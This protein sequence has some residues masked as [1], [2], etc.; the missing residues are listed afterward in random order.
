MLLAGW[1]GLIGY[2]LYATLGSENE[3]ALAMATNT[4]RANFFKDQAFRFWASSKG[5]LYAVV[6]DHTQPVP[7]MAHVPDRDLRAGDGR[8]LTLMNPA[9]MLREMMDQYADLYGIRGRIVGLVTL[10]PDNRA[11]PWEEKAIRAFG[12]GQKEVFE[13]SQVN[14]KP[15][16]RLIR[17]MVMQAPCMK[18]H[19]HLG[20]KIGDVRGAVGVSVPLE[21]YY[22]AAQTLHDRTIM[23]HGAVW[24]MGLVGGGIAFRAQRRRI[25]EREASLKD[26]ALAARVF[27]FGMQGIAITDSNGVI[28]RVNKAFTDITGYPAEEAVGRK[29]SLLKSGM[30]DEAF[31]ERMWRSI[32]S[33][34]H[35]KGEL[36]N[37]HKDGH[38]Y[39]VS[40]HNTAL[41]DD[42]GNVRHFIA[43]F[44]DITDRK[45]AES[46]LL[47]SEARYREAQ[48]TARLGHWSYD[49]ATERFLWWSEETFRLLGI[50]PA[51]GNPDYST[52]ISA[53][54]PED[55]G[56]IDQVVANCLEDKQPFVV[57]YRVP[58][59]G[60]TVR[61]LEAR[62]EVH[63]DQD[64]HVA[65]MSGTVM[66]VSERH[67]AV[68]RLETFRALADASVDAIVMANPD[69]TVVSYANRAAHTM[70]A[71]DFGRQEMVGRAG[72]VFWPPEDLDALEEVIH[73]AMAGGWHGDVRLRRVDGQPFDADIT[74]FAVGKAEGPRQHVVAIIR[75]ITD[76]KLAEQA[77][78]TANSKLEAIIDFLPDATLVTDAQGG[79]IA[80][81][82][83]MEA[84]TGVP[85][86]Q[87]IGQDSRVYKQAFYGHQRPMLVDLVLGRD[88]NGGSCYPHFEQQGDTTV[89]EGY[90][91]EVFGGQGAY[92]WATALPLRDEK[93]VMVGA[94]ECVRDITEAKSAEE[95]LRQKEERLRLALEGTTDGI[96]DWNL[97]SNQAYFSPRYYTML[98]YE[99]GE[100]P[101]GYEGWKQLLHPDDLPLAEAAIQSHLAQGREDSYA[102]EFRCRHKDGSWRWILGRG[103]VVERDEAGNPLRV[104]GS[105][106]DISAR[107]GSEDALLLTQFTVD[108]ASDA[109]FWNDISGRFT[110]VNDMA[111]QSL[112]Y[113]REE[114]LQLG[115][116]DVDVGVEPEAVSHVLAELQQVGAMQFESMHKRKDGSLF[117]VEVSLKYMAFSGEKHM[118]AHAR[119][120]TDRRRA[121]AALLREKQF[122][123][124]VINSL[125]GVFYVFDEH[126]RLV[127]WNQNLRELLGLP[128]ERLSGTVIAD[129]I[130]DQDR[131]L[132]MAKFQDVLVTGKGSAEARLQV[133]GGDRPSYFLTG[134]TLT[135]GGHTYVVGAGVDISAR[136]HAEEELKLMQF[137]VERSS[138]AFFLIDPKNRF[139][140]V[141]NTAC[142]SLGLTRK[143]LLAMSIE[144]IDPDIPGEVAAGMFQSLREHKALHFE[145]R[146]RRKDGSAFPVEVMANYIEFN[147]QE[148]NFCFAR[149][150]SQRKH[151]EEALAR[152][153]YAIEHSS[154]AFELISDTGQVIAC[155]IQAHESLGLTREELIGMHIWDYDP[156][157]A[158]ES[159]PHLWAAL[160]QAGSNVLE[161][162]HR[163]KDGSTFP[164]EAAINHVRFGDQE[165][166]FSYITDITARKAAENALRENEQYLRNLLEQ[167]PGTVFWKDRESVYRGCNLAFAQGAGFERVDDIVG[168]TDY[169][170]PWKESEATAYRRD[171]QEVMQGGRSKLDILETQL[172]ANGKQVRFNTSK[173]PIHDHRGEVVGV[174]GLSHDITQQQRA[175]EALRELNAT[176]ETRVRE[177]AQ[178]NREK[179][180]L[181]IQQSRLAAMGEMI[182]NIAHQWRQPINALGLVLANIRDAHEFGDLDQDYLHTQVDRGTNLIHKMSTTIDDFRN[183]FRPDRSRQVFSLA[184]AVKEALMVVELSFTHSNIRIELDIAEDVSS[185]GL[186][187]EYAQVVLNLLA[188][189]KN[190][191]SERQVQ[192][193]AVHIRVARDGDMAAVTV[194][195]NG[196]GIPEEVLPKVFDPYFTTRESGTGIG[197][198][199]SRMIIENMGGHISVTNTE[200]GARFTLHTP[201]APPDGAQ[202]DR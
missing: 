141:N 199:M 8:L 38:L 147:G 202:A 194:G 56:R 52:F 110:Y 115:V 188:N 162:W 119:D 18:C 179:D 166:C 120:I 193:G 79:V 69:D 187:N 7:Y 161:S 186:G 195:D 84:M 191:I 51:R 133:G 112:G 196:G 36:W 198:Y 72:N 35:W 25:E 113:S 139:R 125:P 101:A 111:C 16:L 32:L 157:V 121:E 171:D 102:A 185:L 126:G 39:A 26:M 86:A 47:E 23:T 20:F 117:P 167:F 181:L 168:M 135:E 12:H 15:H 29:T 150:I 197:L 80:W 165:Y 158:A 68:L 78:Q 76:K 74:V 46:D 144:D 92:V 156:E 130:A 153:Q 109:V 134:R 44:E 90:A 174:L 87:A 73:Q 170:M 2:S 63:V 21:P 57:I 184:Q 67:E 13:V 140:K 82:K 91:P 10:N 5:G 70:F 164:V 103:K 88:D 108:H 42:D 27:D 155:N 116:L 148:Y 50:D 65:R 1:T 189:S 58:Q 175:A 94:I 77:L 97:S 22:A 24:L 152:T 151:A 145:T 95:A 142:A 177:E 200:A 59:N 45:R 55:R 129:M 137:G 85:K 93:G 64:G 169:D 53:V 105:H 9:S 136:K 30:Q 163:R 182:G 172:Q 49:T 66:D 71:C 89:A 201:L 128:E 154:I 28:Q 33:D 96:W 99:P 54:H 4:A 14:G 17:P 40:E 6:D 100:F 81:N 192:A 106:T 118:V 183:F 11:D 107:K 143:E 173:V 3:G 131:G 61:H 104:A 48:R 122:S 41:L 37:R 43:M 180:H 127:R 178:K 62:G 176:L 98:G 19:G 83:A 132:V 34:G 60:G 190:A 114:L 124:S 160:K 75:D 123:D 146:H 138:D 149:D 31:Y 159:W